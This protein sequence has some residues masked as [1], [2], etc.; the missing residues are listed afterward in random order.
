[1]VTV[2]PAVGPRQVLVV[3]GFD[4][5]DK[6]QNFKLTYLTSG[7]T[8]RVWQRYNNSRDDAAV[9]QAAIAAARPGVRVDAASNEAVIQ[10]AVSL[11][12]YDAVVWILGTESTAGRTFDATEQ[13][14]VEQFVALQRAL[15]V[16]GRAVQRE[17]HAHARG[18]RLIGARPGLEERRE[19]GIDEGGA[20]AAPILIGKKA[21]PIGPR[22]AR[23][24][25]VRALIER[26]FDPSS[27]DA[28]GNTPYAVIPG[29]AR[30]RTLAYR[31]GVNLV[32]YALTGNY[33]GDQVHVDTILERLR[34]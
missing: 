16:P 11:A 17:G 14:L 28:R 1:V 9:V 3:N 21:I 32:M 30:Q 31:F 15:F 22:S 18:A 26:G 5:L 4:R 27:V 24:V 8:E 7:T 25:E 33:K 34:R 12:A 20:S 2:Q 19:I 23:L 10:R 6:S 29:G 13:T